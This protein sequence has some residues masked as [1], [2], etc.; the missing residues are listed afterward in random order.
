MALVFSL[1]P[2]FYQPEVDQGY[3]GGHKGHYTKP[4]EKPMLQLFDKA[5]GA[6]LGSISEEQLAFMV[7]Q[8]EEEAAEDTD[9]YLNQA[10]LEMLAEN[11]ADPAL[12]ELLRSAL[13]GREEMDIRWSR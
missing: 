8:L 2:T 1:Y 4:E 6:A 13:A 7:A 5:T 3:T 12:V 10:T 11:G 9:Y